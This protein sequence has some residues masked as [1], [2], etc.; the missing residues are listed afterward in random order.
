[1][2]RPLQDL[3]GIPGAKYLVVCLTGYQRHDRDDIMVLKITFGLLVLV[4]AL[5]KFLSFQVPVNTVSV[6]LPSYHELLCFP[7]YGCLDGRKF[8]EAVG[9]KQGYAPDLLQ[10]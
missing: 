6:Y 5:Y 1:M 3:N 2:Y 10:I 4:L 7:D 9:G 8:F